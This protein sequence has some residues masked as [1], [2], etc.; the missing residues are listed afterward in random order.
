MRFHCTGAMSRLSAR[1]D[2]T[3]AKFDREFDI[4]HDSAA[5]QAAL[6]AYEK[7][8]ESLVTHPAITAGEIEQKIDALVLS[9][10]HTW[11]DDTSQTTM[12]ALHAD[13][14]RLKAVPVSPAMEDALAVWRAAHED[15]A[16][17]RG[18]VLQNLPK[19]TRALLGVPCTTPGDFMAKVYV[20]LIGELGTAAI[21]EDRDNPFDIAID[22]ASGTGYLDEAWRRAAYDDLDHSDLG[23]NL[24]AYGRPTFSPEDWIERA[25]VL[26]I[27][28]SVNVDDSGQRLLWIDEP[29]DDEGELPPDRQRLERILAFDPDR[30]SLL[31]EEIFAN[32]PSLV[33]T[34]GAAATPALVDMVDQ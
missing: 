13:A 33:A 2:E 21:D 1:V 4:D 18:D 20:N 8:I 30:R 25:Q 17:R 3:Y 34:V 32:Y 12:Q 22:E 24:L 6:S 15:M 9:K 14:Q 29:A 11:N 19:A 5:T 10:F 28:I 16:F 31:I 26:G 23:A 7:A 27:G